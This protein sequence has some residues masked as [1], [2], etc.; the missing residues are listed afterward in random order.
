TGASS[1]QNDWIN[2]L[3]L[4]GKTGAILPVLKNLILF[5]CNHP[6]WKNVL[7]FNEFASGWWSENAPTGRCEAGYSLDRSLRDA[8]AQ[9]VPGPGHRGQSRRCRPRHSSC[10]AKEHF[11]SAPRF[12]WRT[13][14]G[15]QEAHRPVANHLS[16]CSRHALRAGHWT[17]ISDQRR[18]A[19]FRSRL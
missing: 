11:P 12:A 4:H 7:G 15:W 6:H 13:A 18:G 3:K 14:M 10:R 1:Q 9:L 8:H 19:N 17:A 2:E 16:A 5:L